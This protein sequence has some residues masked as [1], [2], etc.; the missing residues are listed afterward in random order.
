MLAI[1]WAHTK[2]FAVYDGKEAKLLPWKEV[3]ELA[4][5]HDKVII[6]HGAPLLYLYRL[7]KTAPTYTITPD[8]TAARREEL[9]LAKDDLIDARVIYDLAEHQDGLRLLNLDDKVIQLV[10]LYHQYLYAVKGQVAAG[11]LRK[12]MHRHFGDINNATIFLLSQHEDEFE[13]RCESLKKQIVEL[14]PNPPDCIL[15]IKGISKWLWAGIIICADPRLFPTKSA[16]RKWCGLINRKSIEYKFSRNASKVYW[17]CAD[18][19]IKQNT[20]GW[21]EIYDKAKA[22]LSKR[23]G[24]THPHSGAM[25]R[26]MTAFANYVYDVVK[27][28]GIVEQGVLW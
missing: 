11:H 25:N 21:R 23:E 4:K 3:L 16:Y 10:Y 15:Q 26:V 2:D 19:F 22:E 7:V 9:G 13:R 6:E 24:Y 5:E 17:H 27:E 12:A 28:Q 18:Q 14:A 20:P 8:R 1:N